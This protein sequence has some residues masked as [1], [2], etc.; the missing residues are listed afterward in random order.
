M[1]PRIPNPNAL[2]VTWN[3]EGIDLDRD[4]LRAKLDKFRRSIK[5]P[6]FEV[7]NTV[8]YMEA[9]DYSIEA[10]MHDFYGIKRSLY[11]PLAEGGGASVA[12]LESV[13]LILISNDSHKKPLTFNFAR[14]PEMIDV[15]QEDGSL[16][17]I[18][19]MIPKGFHISGS[20]VSAYPYFREGPESLLKVHQCVVDTCK[21]LSMH[22]PEIYV[23]DNTGFARHRNA[24]RL[25]SLVRNRLCLD[26][27]YAGHMLSKDERISRKSLAAQ[28]PVLDFPEFESMEMEGE[29]L[30]SEIDSN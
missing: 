8:N 6:C 24:D 4:T 28:F 2:R 17:S 27:Y 11:R 1:A 25:Y 23:S 30:A 5:P 12:P 16:G 15:R 7:R 3:G 20:F 10:S 19:S 26:A 29:L 21:L 13:H 18:E 22:F 9:S 14:Y